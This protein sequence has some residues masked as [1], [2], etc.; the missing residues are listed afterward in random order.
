MLDLDE[1]LSLLET[2][3]TTTEQQREDFDKLRREYDTLASKLRY[4]G[5]DFLVKLEYERVYDG[6]ILAEPSTISTSAIFETLPGALHAPYV[7]SAYALNSSVPVIICDGA[8]I[9]SPSDTI[10]IAI[11]R[12]YQTGPARIESRVV[13]YNSSVSEFNI[14]VRVWK[15]L[16]LGGTQ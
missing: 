13:V 10:T 14:A 12:Q 16:G 1:A 6:T 11:Q 9:V 2:L 15:R 5:T 7:L 4:P 8:V 3:K